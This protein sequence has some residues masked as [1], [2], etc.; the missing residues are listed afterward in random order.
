VRIS[1][2]TWAKRHNLA[3]IGNNGRA[4][5]SLTALFRPEYRV[6]LTVHER[7]L[8]D[9][10]SG[11]EV[12]TKGGSVPGIFAATFNPWTQIYR[13]LANSISFSASSLFNYE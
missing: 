5:V 1:S 10:E 9:S 3:A 2:H 13:P 8:M 7:H 4:I 12:A 11:P 6:D